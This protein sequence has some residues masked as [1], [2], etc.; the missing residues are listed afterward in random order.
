MIDPYTHARFAHLALDEMSRRRLP[1]D[2]CRPTRMERVR[3][4]I[5]GGL[6]WTGERIQPARSLTET[7][8][9]DFV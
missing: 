6:I 2:S 9:P 8:C 5:A 4:R 3:A 1:V 7:P